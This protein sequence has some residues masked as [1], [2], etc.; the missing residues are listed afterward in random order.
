[1]ASADHS[2]L[3]A[4]LR[5]QASH[6]GD[7]AAF[8]TAEGN[9]LTYEE[10]DHRSDAMAL[11]LGQRQ[12]QHGARV[13][14]WFDRAHWADFAVAAV[15][16]HKAGAV[17]VPLAGHL[18]PPEV[19]RVMAHCGASGL[20][21]QSPDSLPPSAAWTARPAELEGDGAGALPRGPF[22]D[23]V[24]IV[25]RCRFLG[26]V[27]GHARSQSDI[28]STLDE[29]DG[30][31]LPT[32]G[33]LLHAFAVGT[34]GA[35]RALWSPLAP[36]GGPVLTLEVF[37]PDLLCTLTARWRATRWA[38]D[39]AA[40]LLLLES[41]ALG[42]HDV[43]TVGRV[44]L[45]G[46]RATPAVVSGLAGAMPGALVAVADTGAEGSTSRH[47]EAAPVAASQEG[48]LWHEQ[49]APGS[50]NLPPLVRR[51]QGPLD[52]KVLGAALTEIVRRHEPLRTTFEVRDGRPV[53]VVAAPSPLPVR[54]RDLRESTGP[55]QD[56]ELTRLMAEAGRPFDLVGGPLFEAT[57]VRLRAD[58]HVVMLRVH[59]SVYD[60]WSVGVFRHE[61]SALYAALGAGEASPLP[62]PAVGFADVARRQ[63]E[64][65]DGPE[66]AAELAWWKKRLAGA[67]F[68]LQ[69]PIDDPY[70]PEG[71]QQASAAPVTL[72][73]PPELRMH[74]V[75][76]AGRERA[77][78]FMVVLAAFS[79]LVSRYTGQTDLLLS[80]VVANRNRT[81]LEPMI[82]CFTKKIVLRNDLGGDPSFNEVVA[83][84]RSV[85]LDALSHQDQPFESVVQGGLGAAAA[86]SGLVPYPVVMFQAAT[87]RAEDL[88]LGGLTTMGYDTSATTARPHFIAGGDEEAGPAWGAGLYSGTFLILSLAGGDNLSLVARGAFHRPSVQR[89]LSNFESLLAAVVA[90]PSRP[91]SALAAVDAVEHELLR[92]WN[93]T[94][95][96][97]ETERCLHHIFADQADRTPARVAVSDEH[98]A[99]TFA[100]LDARASALA[101]RLQALGVRTGSVVGLCL[102]PSVDCVAAVLAVWQA[103]AAF[104]GLDERDDDHLARVLDDASVEVVIAKNRDREALRRCRVL[105]ADANESPRSP[106]HSHVDPGAPALAFYGSGVTSVARGVVLEHRAVA[107]L[108]A[109][110]RKAVHRPCFGEGG[111][112][113]VAL[114]AAPTEDA[115][116]R[117]LVAL[118]DGHTLVVAPGGAEGTVTA[119]GEGAIDL[120]DCDSA[121]VGA[122]V[123]GG[124]PDALARRGERAPKPA[125]VVG[126]REP[127]AAGLCRALERL[128]DAHIF[129]IFGP[130]ECSFAT[131]VEAVSGVTARF[132]AGRLLANVTAH[133]L[134]ATGAAVPVRAS[135][136]LHLGG[137][138]L[139]RGVAGGPAGLYPTGR[140]ARHLPDGRLEVG[141]EA[142]EAVDLGGFRVDRRRLEAAL[143]TFPPPGTAGVTAGAAGGPRLMASVAAGCNEAPTL[144]DLRVWL[145]RQLPGFAWPDAAVVSAGGSEP[146]GC[147]GTPL[148]AGRMPEE[149][150]LRTLWAEAPGG[151]EAAADGNYWQRFSFLDVVARVREAGIPLSGRQVTRNR[152]ITT[153]AA[154]MAA[155]R[156][157]P[158]SRTDPP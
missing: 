108:L 15:G 129:R 131:A 57:V 117:Q 114:S 61:L 49:F 9:R 53:Q 22:P 138:S 123:V 30:H 124:L 33:P 7:A 121:T 106:L 78:V 141:G 118:L 136:A 135:G 142:A 47:P 38:L 24:E 113:R 2:F 125:L 68:C 151:D 18:P 13:A 64:R 77:T 126:E 34:D 54:V 96:G 55:E 39:P 87:P 88:S 67:P 110:L 41:G 79:V 94:G 143:G 66:G 132:T 112:A 156:L 155:A 25:Y 3:V 89:L 71:A 153:L 42:N 157:G 127:V 58:D 107:N 12:L 28:F 65:L 50:Q 147:A 137:A 60:D 158:T 100:E 84:T 146:G 109:G 99:L 29:E 150:L 44:V 144:T 105:G 63:R 32:S 40:A 5:E 103:G 73:L 69:L 45:S 48:M 85:L 81:D 98:R 115:F 74:L 86:T 51:Y 27:H 70:L 120:V 119:L 19:T 134:D 43:S 148:P 130:P 128:G 93:D 80:A 82:G 20:V 46:G 140:I 145:W 31:R 95:D 35:R 72:D 97:T 102:P 104:V 6:R 92:T 1:M 26:R 14:L 17:A 101:A 133:V 52:L 56:F 16:V 21:G 139:A 36:A 62:E 91:V 59:H 23:V 90:H 154:D 152:T 111:A 76:L 8:L 4:R 10:W 122:L 37:D 116:L 11:G 75:A 149:E 83:R